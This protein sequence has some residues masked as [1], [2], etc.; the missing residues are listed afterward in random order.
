MRRNILL[1]TT[2]FLMLSCNAQQEVKIKDLSKNSDLNYIFARIE[3][4][5]INIKKM[6]SGSFFVK[7][8][9]MSDSKITPEN[10]SEGTEEFLESIFVSIIPDGDYYTSSK[11]FKIEG[12]ISPEIIEFK[13][14]QYPKFGLRIEYGNYNNRRIEFIEFEGAN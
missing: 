9:I 13:E 7:T 6:Y 10:F 8:F 2:I 11:L 5:S 1:F 14:L 12:L 4:N 3:C